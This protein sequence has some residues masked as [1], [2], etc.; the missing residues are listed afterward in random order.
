MRF[1]LQ[2]AVTKAA[3]FSGTALEFGSAGVRQIQRI[4]EYI[5]TLKVTSAERD[6]GNETYDVYVTTGD[7]GGSWDIVHFPQ[8]ATTGAKTYQARV[9]TDRMAEVTTATP[10]V[11]AEPIAVLK[12]DTA[13]ADQGIKTL[14]AGKVRHGP[15][16]NKFS[17]ELVVAGTVVTGIAYSITV[18]GRG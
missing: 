4:R 6:T 15:I 16:G 7:D 5:F 2:A 8:I 9:M 14:S 17:H 11:A 18:E 1:T 13:A 3:T 12:T 10:G